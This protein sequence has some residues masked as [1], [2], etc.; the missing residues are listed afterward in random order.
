MTGVAPLC[1]GMLVPSSNTALEPEVSRL[2]ALLPDLGVHFS[3]VRVTRI[4]TAPEEDSQFGIEPMAAA[5]TLLGDAKVD[6]VAWAGTSGSW[7]G[8]ERETELL[9]ALTRAATA[10]ATT[11]TVALI[12]ACR[13]LGVNRLG[14]VTPYTADIVTKIRATYARAGL[15]VVGEAHLGIA[16]NWS[17]GNVTPGQIRQLARDAGQHEADAVLIVCTNLRGAG[18]VA[19]LEAELRIPVLDSISATLWHAT[20][21]AGRPL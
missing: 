17:F 10:P 11:S 8:P 2:A 20:S 15:E 5:A 7:L 13:A 19:E 14:L 21:E 9:A 18:V 12:A 6:V 16:D 4:T 1:V 3:R